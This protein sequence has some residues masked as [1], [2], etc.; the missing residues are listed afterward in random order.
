[1][2]PC[3]QSDTSATFAYPSARIAALLAALLSASH[4]NAFAASS[5]PPAAPFVTDGSWSSSSLFAYE[6]DRYAKVSESVLLG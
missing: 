3:L 4:P 6:C 2:R 1:M 5:W